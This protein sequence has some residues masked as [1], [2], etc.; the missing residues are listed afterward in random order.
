MSLVELQVVCL[1]VQQGGVL[2]M[3]LQE[4]QSGIK[5]ARYRT[6]KQGAQ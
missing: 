3:D 2:D 5:E 6:V 4:E 1:Q